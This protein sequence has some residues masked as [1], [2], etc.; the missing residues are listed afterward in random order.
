MLSRLAIAVFACAALFV[1]I[2][3]AQ[4]TTQWKVGDK[5]EILNLSKEWVPGTVIGTVDWNGKTLYRVKLDDE[6][7]PN[8]YFNHTDPAEMRPR[9]GKPAAVPGDGDNGGNGGGEP[10]AG[11]FAV[12][13]KVDTFYDAKHGHNRGSV[14]AL[15][16]RKYKVHYT[17][18]E[19]AFDEWVDASLVR[20]PATISSTAPEITFL[21][22]RWRTTTVAVGGN[23]AVW[24]HSPGIQINSDGTY[25]WKEYESK[26][27]TK[28]TW[29][30]DAKVPMGEGTP[31]F[32]GII[33]KD[34]DGNPWKAFKW[35]VNGSNEDHIEIDRMCSGLSEVGSRVR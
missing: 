18:C 7:A 6:N 10:A 11:G 29:T 5:V 20:P 24:G 28:G 22:G 2:S 35:T 3:F 21:F 32:D 26:P 14:I 25:I 34:A 30:T 16:D 19:T 23:Y 4:D 33:V 17:G 1:T 31:K 12:G 9:G 13:D 8:V 27:A 15:G